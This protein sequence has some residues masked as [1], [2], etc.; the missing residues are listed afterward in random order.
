VHANIAGVYAWSD[1]TVDLSWILNPHVALKVFVSN[2][3][4]HIKTL[5]PACKW[6]HVRSDENPADCA[7]WGCNPAELVKAQ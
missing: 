1:S 4:H 3:V 5:L 2:R 6:A 7:S